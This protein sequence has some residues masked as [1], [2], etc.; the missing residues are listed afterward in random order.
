MIADIFAMLTGLVIV[1]WEGIVREAEQ[2]GFVGVMGSIGFF[3]ILYALGRLENQAARIVKLLEEQR[4]VM[5]KQLDAL[6]DI[7]HQLDDDDDL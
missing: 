7:T 5:T 4:G 6:S 3:Y 2:I 1:A